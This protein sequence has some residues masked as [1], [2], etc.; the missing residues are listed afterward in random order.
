[1]LYCCC[2]PHTW[3]CHL[4]NSCSWC[5]AWSLCC[6][7]CDLYVHCS[8]ISHLN[9][10]RLQSMSML[11]TNF[12]IMQKFCSRSLQY[13]GKGRGVSFTNHRFYN[14][15]GKLLRNNLKCTQGKYLVTTGAV[16]EKLPMILFGASQ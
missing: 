9:Q 2:I 16:D 12:L 13:N 3:F 4:H 14:C 1:M 10:V 6:I 8:A 7:Q 5:K 11:E 15:H